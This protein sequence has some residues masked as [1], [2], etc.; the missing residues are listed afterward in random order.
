MPAETT[1]VPA[2]PQGPAAAL[3]RTVAPF[4]GETVA[5]YIDRLAHANH[6]DPT[7]LRRYL[8][9]PRTDCHPQPGWLA[10]A[11]DQS[12]SLLRTRLIGLTERDRDLSRQ[13]H[14]ARPA[15]R[16]C[17]ARRGVTEP[18]YCWIPD[19]RTVCHRH[20]RWIGPGNRTHDDQRDLRGAPLV[21][22]AARRHARLYRNHRD[23]AHF[24]ITDATRILRWWTGTLSSALSTATT[25]VDTYIGAYPDLI[26][27]ASILAEAGR[28]IVD[29]PAATLARH[30]AIDWVNTRV[31]NRFPAYRNHRQPIEQW[32][33][34]QRIVAASIRQPEDQP[35]TFRTTGARQRIP[36]CYRN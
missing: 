12:L 15:C 36:Q 2:W 19:H 32:I 9:D 27:L 16:F 21:L 8:T 14:H 5:S 28:K 3:P 7:H 25:R 29:T 17:M 18:V 11:S 33:H 24:A 23:A 10:T 4:H 1:T 30:R 35:P 20:D 34:D 26:D 13:R 22:T 6:L 31:A